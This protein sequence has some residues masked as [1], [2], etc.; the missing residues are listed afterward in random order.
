VSVPMHQVYD[1]VGLFSFW[2]NL[3]SR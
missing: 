3:F 2:R 1:G